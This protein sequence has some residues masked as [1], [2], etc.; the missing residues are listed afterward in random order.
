VTA[1]L[2]FSV[3]LA[4]A[5]GGVA[6]RD[7]SGNIVDRVGYGTATNTFVEGTTAA[8]PGSGHSVGRRPDGMDTA[9]NSSDF[10]SITTPTPG[11]AN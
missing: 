3:D 7:P 2:S 6:L 8:A 5:G 9:H 11:A 4:T 10:V 1:D